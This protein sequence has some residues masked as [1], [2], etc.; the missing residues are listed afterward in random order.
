[1]LAFIS[2]PYLDAIPH[3]EDAG[4]LSGYGHSVYAFLGLGA[5]GTGLSLLLMRW[6]REAGWIWLIVSLW[7]GFGSDSYAEWRIPTAI[8][9]LAFLA[10]KSRHPESAGFLLAGILATAADLIAWRIGAAEQWHRSLHYR[11][12]WGTRLFQSFATG[13]VPTSWLARLQNPYFLAGYVLELLVEG[14]I[15]FAALYLFSRQR[16]N[17]R[18]QTK[19]ENEVRE[20]A[21]VSREI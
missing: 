5:I 4:P 13:P 12:D 15:F 20:S 10:W 7:I 9:A 21:V 2:H 14:A 17:W 6:N 8:L 11:V 1:M 16:F 3:F 18:R 19:L